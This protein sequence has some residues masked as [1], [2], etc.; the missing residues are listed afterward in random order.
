MKR[1]YVIA[2]ALSSVLLT[3]VTFGLWKLKS[4]EQQNARTSA[5]QFLDRL[6]H[7]GALDFE[8]KDMAGPSGKLSDFQGKIVILNFWATWCGPC[9]EEI[10]SLAKLVQEFKGQVVL[11]AVSGDES[12]QD[13]KIFLKSFAAVENPNIHVI[14]KDNGSLMRSYEVERLPESFIFGPDLKLK[15]KIIGSINWY[16]PDSVEYLRQMLKDFSTH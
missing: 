10:P 4:D 15:K 3:L 14:W 13:V 16:T 1:P 12:E 7:D 6:E 8:Y 9:V 2:I 5:I 11:L